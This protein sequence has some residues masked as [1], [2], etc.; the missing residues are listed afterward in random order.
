MSTALRH[1][2]GFAIT[3]VLKVRNFR[4]DLG[5]LSRVADVRVSKSSR[6]SSRTLLTITVVQNEPGAAPDLA[7]FDLQLVQRK[8]TV[9]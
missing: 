3:R 5:F 1:C 2:L 8:V 9:K 7:V 4:K 6:A